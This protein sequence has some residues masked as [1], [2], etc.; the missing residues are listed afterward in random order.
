MTTG[1]EGTGAE[2]ALLAELRDDQVEEMLA[3]QQATSSDKFPDGAWPK[4]SS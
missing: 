1:G 4:A 3:L 2:N